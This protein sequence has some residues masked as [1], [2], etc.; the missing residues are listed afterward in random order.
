MYVTIYIL[1]YSSLS[2]QV[3]NVTYFQLPTFYYQPPYN[4][5]IYIYIY[6]IV[7]SV[8]F[9]ISYPLHVSNSSDLCDDST[10]ILI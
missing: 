10:R 3:R 9:R 5:T 2:I 4:G 6:M 1:S 8:Y 7:C